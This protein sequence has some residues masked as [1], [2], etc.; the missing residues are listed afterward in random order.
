[1][2]FSYA[3][4]FVRKLYNSLTKEMNNMIPVVWKGGKGKVGTEAKMLGFF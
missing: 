2:T 3:L 4:N 1:M